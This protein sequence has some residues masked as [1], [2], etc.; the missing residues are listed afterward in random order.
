MLAGPL[1]PPILD[2]VRHGISG[3]AMAG[4]KTRDW[5]PATAE[6]RVRQLAAAA[7]AGTPD[8]AQR[9]VEALAA[10]SRDLYARRALNLNP[11]ANV[12]N[13][14]AEALLAA[15]LGMRPSLGYPGAKYE[16]GLAEIE[17][18]EVIAAELAATVFGAGYAEV[19]V[20]SGSIANLY[21]FLA[22]S[23]PGDAIIAPPAEIGGHVTHHA[24][25]A[26][27]L[28]GLA[29]HAAPIDAARYVVDVDG[30]R[31]LA[32]RVRP[33]L[34]TVGGSLNLEPHPVAALRAIADEVGALL[35]FDAAHLSGPIAGHAW[36]QPL[37]EGAHLMTM[38]TYKSLGGPPSGLVV[39]NDAAIARRLDAIAYPGLTANFDAGKT[40]A[41]AVCLADWL[42]CGRDYAATM[43]A[44]A[45][46]LAEALA[47][48]G[49]PVFRTAAGFTQS[50]QL[51]IV[52]A[53]FGGG[54]RAA[55]RLER[56]NLL[57]SGIGLPL[58]PVDGDMN[59]LRLG[60][61]EIVRIGMGPA[62]M[63]EL[64]HLIAVALLGDQAADG[65]A[66]EVTALRGRFDGVG[67]VA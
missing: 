54:H 29:I 34:I 40:A 49:V 1:P 62:D 59:G 10:A 35:M 13:P 58:A 11:A 42:A 24:P 21:A 23:R 19:R 63:P 9:R 12:M 53:P 60:T 57:A 17:E 55:L 15:G 31:D 38:S 61:P 47:A 37:A 44:T 48:E 8:E 27:G 43:V 14:R 7:R 26:A 41:L 28:C 22:T 67:Y 39:T 36:Q 30:V 32:R 65:V 45:A 50:H 52:A 2:A 6:A 56:A 4:L 25:G 3:D 18:I 16:T 46:A 33:A 64:A 51:A 20:A 5:V 66:A